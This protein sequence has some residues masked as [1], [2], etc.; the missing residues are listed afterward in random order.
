M[1]QRTRNILLL[2]GVSILGG[3]ATYKLLY[4][5]N[6]EEHFE[7]VEEPDI[8]NDTT[9]VD[10]V[11]PQE[12]GSAPTGAQLLAATIKYEG[13][14]HVF[15]KASPED[16]FDCSSL[17]QRGAAD[18]GVQIPRLAS[19]QYLA[20]TP[21]TEEQARNT[22]GALIFFYDKSDKAKGTKRANAFHVAMS[23][24]NGSQDFEAMGRGTKVGYYKWG[25]WYS[26]FR[27][28]LAETDPDKHGDY[29]V[30]YG[31]MPG[32]TYS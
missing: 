21:I 5:F 16:G 29:G 12:D 24:G 22:P 9:S 7:V 13:V 25:W 32:F 8:P 20:S 14:P 11:R 19:N 18:L 10:V 3:W 30:R 26:W 6:P 31:L 27:R 28:K 23:V 15:G 2:G 17:I 1:D 4:A